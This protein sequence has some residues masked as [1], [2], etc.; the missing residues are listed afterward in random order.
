MKTSSGKIVRDILAAL[1]SPKSIMEVAKECN[2]NWESARKYMQVLAEAGVLEERQGG[3]ARVF[4]RKDF[5]RDPEN[6]FGLPLDREMK[7]MIDGLYGA[8]ERAWMKKHGSKPAKTFVYKILWELNKDRDIRIPMGWYLFGA[9][10]VR[11]YS[12]DRQ[13]PHK[14]SKEDKKKIVELVN[15]YSRFHSTYKLMRYHYIEERNELYKKRLELKQLLVAGPPGEIESMVYDF[16]SYTPEMDSESSKLVNEFLA[17]VI[18]AFKLVDKRELPTVQ[19]ELLTSFESLWKLI[20]LFNFKEDMGN[21]YDKEVLKKL[22][23]PEIEIQK[24]ETLEQ[25]LVLS[26]F[27]PE[28]KLSKEE[29]E[30]IQKI[31]AAAL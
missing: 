3:K 27:I 14:V 13:Y 17:M 28:R 15:K 6:F 8:I 19:S 25:F 18:D 1:D 7:E 20:A 21:F 16:V 23:D 9:I 5:L 31:R 4:V 29:E 24:L 10:C 12:P 26:E 30:F 2:I 22:I 11:P